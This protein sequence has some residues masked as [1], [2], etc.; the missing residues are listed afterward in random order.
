MSLIRPA[1][2]ADLAVASQIYHRSLT[3]ASW[4]P[5][6]A[7]DQID[8]I[9]DTEGEAVFVFANE[10]DEVCGFVSIWPASSFIH[11]LYVDARF[12]RKGVGTALLCSLDDWLA[13]PWSLKCLQSN[14]AALAFYLARGWNQIGSGESDGGPYWLLSK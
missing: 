3:A 8:F 12:R 5:K 2:E 7:L 10:S 11:H 14:T 4:L 9:R 13:K 6:T 1:T